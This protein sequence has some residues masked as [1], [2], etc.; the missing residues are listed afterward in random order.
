MLMTLTPAPIHRGDQASPAARNAAPRMK[1]TAK[2]RLNKDI[3][4][5]FEAA[6]PVV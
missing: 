5:M 6:S 2:A 1:F 3:Q 4:R